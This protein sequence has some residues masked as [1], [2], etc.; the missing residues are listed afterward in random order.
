MMDQ[1]IKHKFVEFRAKVLI[2]NKIA[3]KL[4]ASKTTLINWSKIF[5][6]EIGIKSY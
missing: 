2:Y 4:G 5:E 6:N 1:E 3:V